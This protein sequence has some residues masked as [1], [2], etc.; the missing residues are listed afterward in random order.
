[1]IRVAPVEA[2]VSG[3]IVVHAVRVGGATA[4]SIRFVIDRGKVQSADVFAY[5]GVSA[6]MQ[7]DVDTLRSFREFALGFNPKLVTP[8]D[9][10]W[11]PYYGYGAGVVRLSF[12]DNKELGGAVSG[13]PVRWFFFPDATVSVG[14]VVLVDGGRSIAR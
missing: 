3:R 4:D 6:A 11:L 2:T 10:D 12:G 8:S 9:D 7:R 1:V 13:E 14:D 5:Q